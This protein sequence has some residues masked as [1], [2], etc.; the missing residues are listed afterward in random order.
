MPHALRMRIFLI[1]MDEVHRRSK[2]S[3]ADSSDGGVRVSSFCEEE[4]ANTNAS[5]NFQLSANFTSES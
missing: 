1:F 5:A 3:R 2:E 4:F